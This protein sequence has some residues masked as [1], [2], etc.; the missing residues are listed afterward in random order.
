MTIGDRNRAPVSRQTRVNLRAIVAGADWCAQA[1]GPR[2]GG[3]GLAFT[4]TPIPSGS[5]DE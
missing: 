3:A 1:D 4:P 2:G 5:Q